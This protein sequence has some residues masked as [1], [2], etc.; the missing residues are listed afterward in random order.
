MI[1][2]CGG[3]ALLSYWATLPAYVRVCDVILKE[4]CVLW[5]EVAEDRFDL[6]VAACLGWWP[7]SVLG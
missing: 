7:V 1:G 4:V 3:A 2:G 6:M 5:F